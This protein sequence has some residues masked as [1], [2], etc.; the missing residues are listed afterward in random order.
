MSGL[1]ARPMHSL[2]RASTGWGEA[3][4]SPEKLGFCLTTPIHTTR[5]PPVE[6]ELETNGFHFYSIADLDKTSLHVTYLYIVGS[7]VISY[8]CR[9]CEISS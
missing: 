8:A 4:P 9:Q 5:A 7:I 3:A 6:F 1:L 2:N